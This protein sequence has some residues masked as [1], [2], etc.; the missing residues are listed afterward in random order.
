MH[1]TS[2][3]FFMHIFQ[4]WE[5]INHQL[6]LFN[7]SDLQ[8]MSVLGKYIIIIR[9]NLSLNFLNCLIGFLG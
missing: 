7:I 2:A 8:A 9:S 4:F 1:I 6:Y 3:H 5:E